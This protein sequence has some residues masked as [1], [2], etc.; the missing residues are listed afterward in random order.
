MKKDTYTISSGWGPRWGGFHYGLDFAAPDGTPFYACAG[1]TVLY[2]GP[3][4]GYGQWIVIDHPASEGGGCTEYGHM[5]NA[6][7]TGLKVGSKVEAGQHIGYVGSNGTSTG[8]HLH[9]TVWE[10][11]YGGRRI[12]PARWLAGCPHPGENSAPEGDSMTIF[13]VDVSEHQAGMSLTL[14]AKE[15][16][17]DFAIIRTTDGTHRDQR[18]QS[19]LRD[20]EG[21]GL[22]TAAYHYLRNPSEGRSIAAQ[23][24]AS[25]EV[26]GNQQRPMWI[27]VE[28]PAGI[29]VD[30]IRECK[31]RF[32]EAGVR[33]IGCYSYVP[34][35]EHKIAPHEPDS[36][37]FG[38]FWVA[39]YGKNTPGPPK[40]IYPGNNHRQW[41]YPLGSQKPALWQ[42]SSEARFGS[43]RGGNSGVD[44]NA[45]RGTR[46]QLQALFYGTP[47]N[48][49]H[50]EGSQG[51]QGSQGS[52]GEE[53]TRMERMT[54][55][56]LDQFVGPEW[57][58]G[59][60]KFTGWV[61]TEGRTFVDYVV[62]KLKLI[63]EMAKVVAEVPARLDRNE[64][65]LLEMAQ[66][67]AEIP[68]R[69]DKI[70]AEL[71][72]KGGAPA[73]TPGTA[74]A[75]APGTAPAET[76][77]ETSAEVPAAAVTGRSA[78]R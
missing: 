58:D 28:T 40:N 18:Y 10:R 49:E 51:S 44:I 37:E 41:N 42:F 26:M 45:F 12:D 61:Q 52:E 47:S 77:K 75:G 33:V 71:K 29:H 5:W 67:V 46:E 17:L 1:G 69:L 16:G 30:H 3:A 19:H 6:Y 74:P 64:K 34:Y 31:R 8:P 13:G 76:P 21:A 4:Q 7:A 20:A 73:G 25:L 72:A 24:Q 63:P 27:D 2:I 57:S 48:S 53:K 11:G 35:W 70:E 55:W 56:L 68:A 14:A 39:A 36:H 22:I 66:A 54:R 32:E 59:K 9:L 62:S 38:A 23:V 43:W 78:R 15:A 60:P 65:L 50:S